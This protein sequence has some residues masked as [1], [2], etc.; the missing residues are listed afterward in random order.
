MATE[1]VGSLQV[2]TIRATN[3]YGVVVLGVND[4]KLLR[5]VH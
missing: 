5:C 1:D 2:S 4:V 3:N